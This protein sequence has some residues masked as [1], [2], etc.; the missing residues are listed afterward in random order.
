M[1]KLILIGGADGKMSDD[2][3]NIYIKKFNIR[4]VVI[5]PAATK[6]QSEAFEKYNTFFREIGCVVSSCF[7]PQS[8]SI[9]NDINNADMVFLT[10]GDQERLINKLINTECFNIIKTKYNKNTLTIS[11]TSA[12]AMSVSDS[13]II[14]DKVRING[15]SLI[16]KTI[17]THFDERNRFHRMIPFLINNNCSGYGINEDSC[18]V[19]D[20]DDV[21]AYGGVWEFKNHDSVISIKKL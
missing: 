4:Y 17:D 5:I 15:L 6:Y 11:G 2:V 21:A 7:N 1:G 8:D 19:I 12:G 13:V 16:N 14:G 9:I 3:L 10:G 18:L 20:G